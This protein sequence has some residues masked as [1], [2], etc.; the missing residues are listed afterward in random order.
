MRRRSVSAL[1]LLCVVAS[2]GCGWFG[3]PSDRLPSATADDLLQSLATRRTAV[4]S[5]R[6]R[7]RLRKGAASWW[8]HQAI[9]VQRPRSIRVDVMSPFGLAL[10]LGTDGNLLW[11]YPPQDGVRYEGPA[12]A[13]NLAR[14][15]GAAIVVD[16]LVDV[17]MGLPP[18]RRPSAAPQLTTTPE[19][20]YRLTVP[21]T[22]GA[23]HL[24]FRGNPLALVRADETRADQTDFQV[25]FGEHEAGF[26][27]TIEVVVPSTGATVTLRYDQ[28]EPNAA[29]D[30]TVFAPPPAPSVHPLPATPGT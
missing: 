3:R 14:I 20:E 21:L 30:P 2:S 28:V 1:V 7:A 10:A 22:G 11:A 24:W 16:D 9:L 25:T 4:S 5:L 6:T 26:P 18:L 12:T 27:R 29:L 15:L 19:Q 13:E 17:L 8:T 23:Q